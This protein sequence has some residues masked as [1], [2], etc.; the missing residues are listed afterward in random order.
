[1]RSRDVARTVASVEIWTDPGTALLVP[2]SREQY[3]G[4]GEVAHA[5]WWD[6]L[7]VVTPG[8]LRHQRYQKR[9][10]LLLEPL[11]PDGHELFFDVGVRTKDS[12]FIPDI[13]VVP[14]GA[15]VD[16]TEHWFLDPPLFVLEVLSP[17]TQLFDLAVKRERY[18]RHGIPWYWLFDPAVP[19]LIILRNENGSYVEEQRLRGAGRPSGPIDV[20]VDVD[21]ICAS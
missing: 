20:T 6:G 3:D 19:E 12:D 4:I 11:T 1:M 18:A 16:E 10:T 15:R 2:M 14:K 8:G 17:S 21:A 7:C 9:L 5:E 13:A